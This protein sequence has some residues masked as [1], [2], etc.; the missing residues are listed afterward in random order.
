M[1]I[2]LKTFED[3]T[4]SEQRQHL[5]EILVDDNGNMGPDE[6]EGLRK[7]FLKR[8]RQPKSAQRVYLTAKELG[9]MVGRSAD[10]IREMFRNDK[11]VKKDTHSGRGRKTYTTM[12]I[13]RA[14]AKR[15]FPDLNI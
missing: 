4:P 12:L 7:V 2:E 14:A 10:T 3:M 9:E 8:I 5:L 13:P 6:L 1:I 11:G 15:R